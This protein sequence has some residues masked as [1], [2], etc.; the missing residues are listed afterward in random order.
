M[1]GF[2]STAS[3][4]GRGGLI[5][6]RASSGPSFTVL[7]LHGPCLRLG[8]WDGEAGRSGSGK[9]Q[10]PERLRD[11]AA[12]LKGKPDALLAQADAL[13]A[14]AEAFD[15]AEAEEQKTTVSKFDPRPPAG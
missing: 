2:V 1:S 3:P 7:P 6:M 4:A 10:S 11:L 5:L 9:C 8:A 15:A 13:L 12:K 14:E